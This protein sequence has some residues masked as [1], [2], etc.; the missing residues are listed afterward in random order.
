MLSSYNIGSAVL[1]VFMFSVSTQ[2][3]VPVTRAAAAAT[4]LPRVEPLK[5]IG[6]IF[7]MLAG[8]PDKKQ[9]IAPEKALPG[10][11][12]KMAN[13]DN[14][15]HYVLGNK[16]DEVPEGHE[17]AVFANGCFWGSEKGA[18]VAFVFS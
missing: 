15:R 9:L 11:D 6:S 13:I 3:F 10:R 1:A 18:L 7:D 14:L 16:L 8:G 2:A 12:R 17:V 4:F 5:M